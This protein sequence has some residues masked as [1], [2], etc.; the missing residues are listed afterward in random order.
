MSFPQHIVLGALLA[1]AA[2]LFAVAFYADHAHRRGRLR[3]LNSP[4]V[5]TLSITVYCTS[6]TFYGA[7]GTAARSGL[8]FL[9]IYL[10]PTLVFVGWWALMRRIVR[11]GRAQRTTSIADFLSSRYGKSP[12]LAAMV[13]VIAVIVIVPY[14]ALQLSA[15]SASFHALLPPP[16]DAVAQTAATLENRTALWLA[17]GLALFAIMFGTRNLDANERHLGVVAAVALEAVVK[18]GAL[19]A[20]GAFATFAVAGGLGEVMRRAPEALA[21]GG[22]DARWAALTFLSAAAV[23]CLPR[24][25]HVTVVECVDERHG[26][27]AAWLFPLYMLLIC[28]FVA[29]IAIV[30]LQTLPEGANPDLFVLSLPLAENQPALA[31]LVFLGGFSSATSMVVISCIALSTMISNHLAMPILLKR[32]TEG[33]SGDLRRFLLTCRRVAIGVILALGFLYLVWSGEREPLASIGLISFAGVAQFLPLMIAG[34]FWRGA[35]AAGAMTG[36]AFGFLVWLVLLFAPSLAAMEVPDAPWAAALYGED[37]LVAA[38]FWSLAANIAGLVGV[39]LLRPAPPLERI[40]GALFLAA[41]HVRVGDDASGPPVM[42]RTAAARDVYILAQRILGAEPADA[43]FAEY[44][45]RQGLTRGLPDIDAALIADLERRFAAGVGAASAQALVSQVAVGGAP[46]LE[47]LVQIADENARLIH[48]SA[49]LEQQSRALRDSAA[50]LSA[51]NARLTALDAQKDEL[52][53]Q[54]SHELR[55]PM[56]SIA[57]F[58]ELLRRPDALEPKRVARFAEIINEETQRLTRLLDQV[59]DFSRIE[60]GELAMS[61]QPI[62]PGAVIERALAAAT[63]PR[64]EA[65][66]M[67]TRGPAPPLAE[68]GLA[69]I[70]DPDRIQQVLMNVLTNS[71][72]FNGSERPHIWIDTAIERDPQIGAAYVVTISDDGPGVAMKDRERIFD[73]FERGAAAE[74]S[75]SGVGLGLAISREIMARHGGLITLAPPLRSGASFRIA[76]PASAIDRSLDG[77]IS[78]RARGAEPSLPG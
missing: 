16:G 33:I 37:P 72:K 22:F 6:W 56:T 64:D 52:L 60:R 4:I 65:A 23:L 73:K 71:L 57:A 67:V 43:L 14:I 48:Y 55:T 68:R 78:A 61:L 62:D 21:S 11:I 18:L 32:R 36:L 5:Y 30:G 74:G 58:S 63:P 66:P 29:P 70:A 1:Y 25:F 46:A 19:L 51:A 49:K 59:L 40:Q 12:G 9:T 28:I 44:R 3:W 75:T 10:G 53:A 76:L 17:A 54:I 77:A 69:V 34:L 35:T 26:A 45:A 38:L 47:G 42:Q 2:G 20:V 24:Q 15:V 39:S 27:T 13:T 7:V 8:E 31:L 50:E 41:E